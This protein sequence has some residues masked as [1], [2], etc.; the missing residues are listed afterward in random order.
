MRW[1]KFFSGDFK[2]EDGGGG[3]GP[4]EADQP[5]ARKQQQ[6][7]LHQNFPSFLRSKTIICPPP[8]SSLLPTSN[9]PLPLF[10]FKPKPASQASGIARMPRGRSS[11]REKWDKCPS[12]THENIQSLTPNKSGRGRGSD[13]PCDALSVKMKTFQISFGRR[14]VHP[15]PQLKHVPL[16]GM[17]V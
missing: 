9:L 14:R 1:R 16:L 7:T 15:L 10:R 12:V 4:G 5:S 6:G 11:T 13:L 8:S 17:R 3:S 2:A